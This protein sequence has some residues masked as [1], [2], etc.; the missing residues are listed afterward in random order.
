MDPWFFLI[1][2]PLLG[3]RFG[4][5]CGPGRVGR[6]A[7]VDPEAPGTRDPA[8]KDREGDVESGLWVAPLHH[9]TRV[10]EREEG[11]AGERGWG[12]T[13]RSIRGH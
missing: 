9:R 8:G 7:P 6:G 11:W 10:E 1:L 4:G 13:K 12:H 3:P 5:V 2:L